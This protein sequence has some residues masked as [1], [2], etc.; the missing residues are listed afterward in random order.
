MSR[1]TVNYYNTDFS[2]DGEL[3]I[4]QRINFSNAT[5]IA[6][7]RDISGFTN[8]Q[9]CN[10]MY[11]NPTSKEVV[12]ANS[13]NTFSGHIACFTSERNSSLTGPLAFGNGGTAL[14]G[15]VIPANA[16]ILGI[17]ATVGD[18]ATS[19]GTYN[20]SPYKNRV[21]VGASTLTI[22]TNGG[23]S[24]NY[25]SFIGGLPVGWSTTDV[26]LSTGDLLSININSI[27]GSFDTFVVTFWIQFT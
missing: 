21:Q 22:L 24:S 5:Y 14:N 3:T 16:R 26:E 27:T 12:Q 11:Y 25:I 9:S 8:F 13:T 6:P 7:I 23:A 19:P 1:N 2:I 17:G 10:L 20:I 15:V 4:G 18:G